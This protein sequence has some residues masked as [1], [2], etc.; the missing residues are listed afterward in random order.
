MSVLIRTEEELRCRRAPPGVPYVP[1]SR[2][3]PATGNTLNS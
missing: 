2:T 1:Y 3:D